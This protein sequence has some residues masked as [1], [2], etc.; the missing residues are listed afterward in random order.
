MC[1]VVALLRKLD[2]KVDACT[3]AE[4][5]K[6]VAHRGPDGD[7][8]AFLDSEGYSTDESGGWTVGLG[9]RRLS[10]LDLSAAGAQPMAYDGAYWITYNGEIYNFVELRAQLG[11]LGHKFRSGSDTEV[12][13]AAY[14]EWGLDAFERLRGMWGLVLFDVRE[15]RVVLSRDRLGIKPLYL[16][17][18]A[19]LVAV[20]SEP[21]QL[22]PLSSLRPNDDVVLSYLQTGYEVSGAT[23]FADVEPVAP[24]T[25][26]TID[27][28]TLAISS[29]RPYWFP[30]RITPSIGDPREAAHT[31]RTHLEDA[32]RIHLRSDVPV[33]CAL[34]GGL[35][36]TAIA[37]T[38]DALRDPDQTL[39][40]FSVMFPGHPMDE[41]RYIDAANRAIRSTPHH[42][43]PT[44]ADVLDDFDRF[45]FSHDEPVGSLSQYAAYAV[46]RLTRHAG[47]PVT[48]NGQGGDEILSGYWQCYFAHMKSEASRRRVFPLA[49][50]LLGA[51]A[52]GGNRE[53]LRQFPG[54]ARRYFSRMNPDR[55]L[56]VRGRV[57]GDNRASHVLG[58]D[59]Q[60]RRVYEIRELTLP[61]LLKWDDR[62]FMAFSV[63]GRYPML[64]HPLIELCLSFEPA[65]LY[66]RGWAKNPLRA[67]LADR[68]PPEIAR[69]KDKIG[70]E[71]PQDR[72]LI[73]GLKATVEAMLAER[74]S[75]VWAYVEHGEGQR[76]AHRVWDAEARDRE[77]MQALFR[78]LNVDRWLRVFRMERA[79]RPL[80]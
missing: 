74:G 9:H 1:G 25:T 22:A 65:V 41:S 17:R 7:G 60:A 14:A 24:G 44:A 3:L 66:D 79:A 39:H 54:M 72:W 61:R 73:A 32:T 71:T 53:L 2:R 20:V 58:L 28:D 70:F 69:R 45:V 56:A 35:D 34:S 18:S 13:L 26:V 80:L 57:N 5:T 77:A 42:V 38:V 6:L 40:T 8:L 21:K 31:F 62:N 55:M 15:R 36:S 27:M 49:F 52:P 50:D 64:D 23:F 12:L 16:L 68:L 48:L 19:D 33:G 30:E 37:V 51:A 10:I 63:E 67:G 11:E 29:P 76:L 78:V 43:T 4:M 46:A 47:V 75:P 59:P